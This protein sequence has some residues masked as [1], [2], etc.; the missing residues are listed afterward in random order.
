M[1]PT[2][3][4]FAGMFEYT[5]G[6]ADYAPNSGRDKACQEFQHVL[7]VGHKPSRVT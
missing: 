7:L 1:K 4:V 5:S 3:G 2:I 6:R